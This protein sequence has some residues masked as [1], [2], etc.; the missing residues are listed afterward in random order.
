MGGSQAYDDK[1]ATYNDIEVQHPHND[2]YAVY[3]NDKSESGLRVLSMLCHKITGG[4]N[5]SWLHYCTLW[6]LLVCMGLVVMLWTA[7]ALYGYGRGFGSMDTGQQF[8]RPPL[9]AELHG[10]PAVIEFEPRFVIDTV[11]TTFVTTTIEACQ[12]FLHA[13]ATASD[14]MDKLK[15]S[16]IV[17]PTNQSVSTSTATLTTTAPTSFATQV[18]VTTKS[19]DPKPVVPTTRYFH[20]T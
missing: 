13:N 11:H 12:N 20:P 17:N 7:I 3:Q 16:S 15:T 8:P 2:V 14:Q 5:V 6:I 9:A 4:I 10:K 19:P 1:S 18:V